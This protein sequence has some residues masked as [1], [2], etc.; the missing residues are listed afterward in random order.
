MQLSTKL[1]T[2]SLLACIFIC[3]LADA[4]QPRAYKPKKHFKI[5]NPCPARI[6]G[7]NKCGQTRYSAFPFKINQLFIYCFL[8]ANWTLPTTG[9]ARA[10]K[11]A[12]G[13]M[14]KGLAF[15]IYIT[16]GE[17]SCLVLQPQ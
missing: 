6:N 4:K 14:A 9:Y 16:F 13:M 8:K 1:V 15:N 10:A 12:L 3:C 5:D 11:G 7:V 17:N 2:N